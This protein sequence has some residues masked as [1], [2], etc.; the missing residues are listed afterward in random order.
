MINTVAIQSFIEPE[1]KIFFE[2]GKLPKNAPW[3][4]VKKIVARKLDM[5]DYAHTLEDLQSPPGNRLESLGEDLKGLHSIRINNQWRVIFE[6]TNNGPS[7]VCV[8]DYH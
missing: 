7:Q 5:L 8:I 1:L 2:A 3:Q 6:W 4:G